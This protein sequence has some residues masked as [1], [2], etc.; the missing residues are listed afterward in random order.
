M[1]IPGRQVEDPCADTTDWQVER[2]VKSQAYRSHQEGSPNQVNKSKRGKAGRQVQT[3]TEWQQVSRW[4][5]KT[6][7]K[8]RAPGGQVEKWQRNRDTPALGLALSW[9]IVAIFH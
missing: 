1:S 2:N 9:T 3:I 5:W 7:R 8:V 4:V 6:G